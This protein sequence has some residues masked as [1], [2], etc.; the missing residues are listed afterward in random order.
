MQKKVSHAI[1]R[2]SM[3]GPNGSLKMM[4]LSHT[5]PQAKIVYSGGSGSIYGQEYR[6]ADLVQKMLSDMGFPL[7]HFIA[8][9]KSRTTYENVA[10][11]KALVQP[12]AGEN[13]LLITSAFHMPRSTRVFEKQ[14]WKIIPYPAGY[15]ENDKLHAW[16]WFDVSGNYWKLNVAAKEMIGIIAY[17]LSG[18]I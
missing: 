7:K 16:H 15:I 5:Y 10:N 8:E 6:E 3:N 14:G 18:R 12:Q 4:R 11:S 13:W 2:K 9:N 1:S 17:Q